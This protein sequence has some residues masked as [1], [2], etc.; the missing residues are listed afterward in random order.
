MPIFFGK[1]QI[2]VKV[3]IFFRS[4]KILQNQSMILE[5]IK[6]EKKSANNKSCYWGA[7]GLVK[8]LEIVQGCLGDSKSC[9]KPYVV[10]ALK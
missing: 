7:T 6:G 4:S 5:K 8:R 1:M 9:L 10:L 3:G 2:E